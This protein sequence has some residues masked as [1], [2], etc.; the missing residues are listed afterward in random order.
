MNQDTDTSWIYKHLDL[1]FPVS[2][3]MRTILLGVSQHIVSYY[4]VLT[5]LSPFLKEDVH[6]TI[7]C[8]LHVFMMSSVR[9]KGMHTM[10]SHVEICLFIS[11]N[12]IP[13][14]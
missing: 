8:Q 6:V 14:C 2:K 12:T 9:I 10:L 5:E 1:S 3:N 4:I 13:L 11:L 7:T